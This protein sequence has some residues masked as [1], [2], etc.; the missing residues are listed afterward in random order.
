MRILVINP[1]TSVSMTDHIRE[2]LIPIKRKDTELTVVCPDR[3]PETIESAYDEAYAIPPTLELVSKANEEGY[4]AGRHPLKH[5]TSQPKHDTGQYK[6]NT[7]P[8]KDHRVKCR[9]QTL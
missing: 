3:G 5:R 1:N 4:D 7:W 8:H 2:A 9:R 6:Q